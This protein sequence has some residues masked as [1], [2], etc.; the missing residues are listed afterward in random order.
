MNKEN[1][2]ILPF[3]NNRFCIS[4]KN[5]NILDNSQGFGYKS[6]ESARKSMMLKYF[7]IIE[8]TEI[9]TEWNYNNITFDIIK[10]KFGYLYSM[11]C[12]LYRSDRREIEEI[13]NDV[14]DYYNIIIPEYVKN[15]IKK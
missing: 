7:S 4:D 9:P 12:N 10:N 8:K 13:W 11:N 2:L 6:E 1:F 5:G 3:K 15:Y 14:E